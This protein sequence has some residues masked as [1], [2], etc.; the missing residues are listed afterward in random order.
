VVVGKA[1][2]TPASAQTLLP[3]D[4]AT[5]TGVAGIATPTG[6]VDFKLFGPTDTTCSGTPVFQQLAVALTNG[7][8][9]TSNTTFTVDASTA[10]TYRWTV[11]YSGDANYLAADKLCGAEQFTA[12][13]TN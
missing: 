6:T 5:I 9:S 8:A 4:S 11:H 7:S 10:G 13:I 12:S 2:P 3:N 1:T